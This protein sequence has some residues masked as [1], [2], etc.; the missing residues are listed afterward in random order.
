MAYKKWKNCWHTNLAIKMRTPKMQTTK[1]KLLLVHQQVSRNIFSSFLYSINWFC[2]LF[3]LFR[4]ENC[5]YLNWICK[6][7]VG[8]NQIRCNWRRF[9]W[10]LR[11]LILNMGTLHVVS[12]SHCETWKLI[13]TETF[14]PT[15]RQPQSITWTPELNKNVICFKGKCINQ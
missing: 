4:I 7:S 6:Q 14:S 12:W 15:V 9:K 1:L 13:K 5:W 2:S 11:K 10:N 8:K 3:C